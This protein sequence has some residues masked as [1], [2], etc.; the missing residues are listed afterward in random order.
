MGWL[1]QN[2]YFLRKK[3]R[4][5]IC[6]LLINEWE[7]LG[8]KVKSD[9]VALSHPYHL[10]QNILK[11]KETLIKQ[12]SI[13]QCIFTKQIFFDSICGTERLNFTV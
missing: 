3:F 4:R 6:A 2:K 8:R 7:Y 11:Y 13:W 5:L 1:I 12:R 9:E 10:Q